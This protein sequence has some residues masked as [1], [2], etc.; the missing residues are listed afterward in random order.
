VN[1]DGNELCD[2]GFPGMK[3]A[4]KPVQAMDKTVKV[5]VSS[6]RQEKQGAAGASGD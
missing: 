6:A 1:W 3:R 2:E 5:G 4:Y